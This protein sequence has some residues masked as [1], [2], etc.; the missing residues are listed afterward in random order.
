MIN[1][2]SIKFENLVSIDLVLNMFMFECV[3]LE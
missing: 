1:L 3:V 2:N